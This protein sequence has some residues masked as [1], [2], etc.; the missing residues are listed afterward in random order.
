MYF[1]KIWHAAVSNEHLTMIFQNERKCEQSASALWP[2]I[3][4]PKITLLEKISRM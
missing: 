2:K 4:P 3:I 1:H